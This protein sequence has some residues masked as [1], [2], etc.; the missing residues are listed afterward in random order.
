MEDNNSRIGDR[1]MTL[2]ERLKKIIHSNVFFYCIFF[3]SLILLMSITLIWAGIIV[4]QMVNSP[5]KDYSIIMD[6]AQLSLTLFGFTLI[7]AIFEKRK[8][9]NYDIISRLFG[10]SLLFLISFISFLFTYSF[11]KSQLLNDKN[12]SQLIF[13]PVIILILGITLF[14]ISLTLLCFILIKYFISMYI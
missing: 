9:E 7:G 1:A 4:Q 2:K 14:V 10:T 3:I 13:I 12:F 5:P 6:Y 8:P 11:I